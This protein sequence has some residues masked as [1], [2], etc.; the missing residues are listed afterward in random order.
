M[1]PT[2]HTVEQFDVEGENLRMNFFG[3]E[4]LK[5][6]KINVCRMQSPLPFASSYLVS[7]G[8]QCCKWIATEEKNRLDVNAAGHL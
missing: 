3:G 8:F 4:I 1:G 5:T 2:T 7:H 6:G